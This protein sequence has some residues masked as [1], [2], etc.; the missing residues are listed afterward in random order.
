MEQRGKVARFLNGTE[1]AD[2]LD[3]LV[4]DMGCHDGLPGSS[5]EPSL[6]VYLKPG[7]LNSTHEPGS[8]RTSFWS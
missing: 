2:K 5:S 6:A 1:D 3:S 7:L 4:E 8:A